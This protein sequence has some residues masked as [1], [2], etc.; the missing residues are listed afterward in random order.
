MVRSIPMIVLLCGI[1]A[2]AQTQGSGSALKTPDAARLRQQTGLGGGETDKLINALQVQI[3]K[4][5]EDFS[6]YDRLGTA[7]LQKARETG[8]LAYYELA[9]KTLTHS[10]ELVSAVPSQNPKAVDPLVHMALVYMGE[11]R[12]SE[13]LAASQK[14]AGMGAGNLIAFAIAGDAYTDMG[15]YDEA[16]AAYKA[17]QTIGAASSLPLQ[18]EYMADSRIAYLKFLHGDTPASIDLLQRSILAAL[19]LHVPAENLAWLYYELGERYF[20]AGDLANAELAYSSGIATDAIHYRS[21]AGLAKVRAAQGKFEKSIEL[22][23]ASIAIVPFPQYIAELGDVY[24]KPGRTT[25]AQQQ[26]D[27]VEY[28]GYLSKLNRVLN[29]RELAMFYAD[30]EI[31]L[32]QA[33]ELARAELD[34]RRDIY[35]WDTLAWVQ[36]K[37]RQLAEAEKSI[38]NALSLHTEDSLILFHAGMIYR[39][40]GQ[41]EAADKYLSRALEI[42]PHFHIFYAD[43]ASRTVS[44]LARTRQARSSN[45]SH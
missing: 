22:Y 1:T 8:D 25:E 7:Y 6:T 41:D 39:A 9:E 11:H 33:L 44:E 21:L 32:P 4:S 27:L 5:P 28:I 43:E 10:L 34:V 37:N 15:D 13:A 26:Y 3:K 45:E 14:A 17:L 19:Q 40:L 24:L 16:A 29:N 23:Q 42:N 35:T 38:T 18:V 2:L 31:K 20:Q 36:Y 12:F 30:R